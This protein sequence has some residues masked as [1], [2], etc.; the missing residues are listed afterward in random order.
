VLILG[1]TLTLNEPIGA[2]IA[3]LGILVMRQRSRLRRPR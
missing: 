2:A 1:E 3:I